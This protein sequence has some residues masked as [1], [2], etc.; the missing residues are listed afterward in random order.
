MREALVASAIDSA[1]RAEELG[2]PG[3]RIVLSCKVSERAGPDRRL[4]ASSRAAATTRC[5]S[6]SPRPAWAAR[7]SS[8]RPPRWPCCC[9][10]AS[11][12]RSASRSRP[13]PNGDRTRE[14]IVAQEIL[15]T[16]GLRSFTPHGH[17]VPGLRPHDQHRTSRSSPSRS[18]PTCARRCRCGA[19]AIPGVETMHVAVMGCVV[20]G[21][22]ESK[23]AN[24]G[25]SLPGTGETPVAPV[26]VDGAEDGDAEGRAH[27]R[28]VP[29]DRRRLRARDLR[30]RSRA[31]PHL[32]PR[33]KIDRRQG[34]RVTRNRAL[35]TGPADARERG[36]R[37]RPC[38][39]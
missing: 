10:K 31:P 32:K 24:I 34:G 19:R 8:P 38:A 35:A 16:M 39:A 15:Q 21:P 20:N 13:S 27:R 3:D 11:A 33:Q 23:L 6:A 14:V 5:T 22:G 37:C 36:Q 9:R 18:R 1:Q 29:G 2:L 26:Y 4:L 30:R 17:R 12:T 25:I 7:A 28:G